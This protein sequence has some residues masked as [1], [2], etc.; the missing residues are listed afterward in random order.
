MSGLI[1]TED[2]EKFFS[3]DVDDEMN[4]TIGGVVFSQLGRAPAVGDDIQISGITFRVDALDGM[5]ID[6]LLVRTNGAQ[7]DEDS[8]S[9]ESITAETEH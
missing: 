3:L 5:R 2:V 7:S 4:D 1:L 9:P 8:D 6:R